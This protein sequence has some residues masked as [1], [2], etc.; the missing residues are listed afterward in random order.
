MPSISAADHYPRLMS[1][2]S[3]FPIHEPRNPLAFTGLLL[4]KKIMS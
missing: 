3:R 2:Y 4:V 1:G